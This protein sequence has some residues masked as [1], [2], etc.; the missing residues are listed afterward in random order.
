MKVL[1]VKL[2]SKD[3]PSYLP[4]SGMSLMVLRLS[5]SMIYTVGINTVEYEVFWMYTTIR[6]RK[7]SQWKISQKNRNA[8]VDEGSHSLNTIWQ[9][10]VQ[11]VQLNDFCNE[12]GIYCYLRALFHGIWKKRSWKKRLFKKTVFIRGFFFTRFRK[13]SNPPLKIKKVESVK[14]W[15]ST[16]FHSVKITDLNLFLPEGWIFSSQPLREG[17]WKVEYSRSKKVK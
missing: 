5:Y 1:D 17:I 13:H 16:F 10:I 9:F 11:V 4:L 6:V 14:M 8:S 12:R 3:S 2:S 7:H 15:N